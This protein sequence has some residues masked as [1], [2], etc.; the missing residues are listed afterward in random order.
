MYMSQ[1]NLHTTPDFE[2][3]LARL[4]KARRFSTKSEAIRVAVQ[5]ATERAVRRSTPAFDG[6][7]GQGNQ[8]P[9]APSPRFRTDDDLWS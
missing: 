9:I 6:W 4:M 7:L 2:R 3:A 5:E 8:A 1:I